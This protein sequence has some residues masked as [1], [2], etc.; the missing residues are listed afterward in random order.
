MAS[1][2]PSRVVGFK[3][4][5][6]MVQ[7]IAKESSPTGFKVWMLVDCATNYVVAFDMFT[8][9]KGRVKESNASAAVVMKLIEWLEVGERGRVSPA[10]CGGYGPRSDNG[11]G[12]EA[13]PAQRFLGPLTVRAQGL[14]T[15]LE[16][17]QKVAASSHSNAVGL[18]SRNAR[19]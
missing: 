3:G 13:P 2:C 12:S 7:F 10:V 8:G 9:R 19:M 5:S 16:Q 1:T 18:R 4:R 14:P 17:V 15:Q 11:L 6:V